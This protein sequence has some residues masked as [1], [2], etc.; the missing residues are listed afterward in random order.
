MH[1]V[2]RMLFEKISYFDGDVQNEVDL[3]KLIE[4]QLTALREAFHLPLELGD[5]ARSKVA[6]KLLNLYRTGRLGHYTLDPLAMELTDTEITQKER[7]G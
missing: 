3:Q 2:R 5:D 6:T 1:N 7:A 4:L